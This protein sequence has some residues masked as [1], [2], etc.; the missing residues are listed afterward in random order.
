M[1]AR[2]VYGSIGYVYAD[3]GERGG[4]GGRVEDGAEEAAGAGGHCGGV[5]TVVPVG[6][7][8]WEVGGL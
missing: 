2:H 6:D 8:R 3:G 7:A 5:V 4:G 1:T